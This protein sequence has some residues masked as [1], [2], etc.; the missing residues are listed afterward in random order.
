M[1]SSFSCAQNHCKHQTMEKET[2]REA[3][4]LDM[5]SSITISLY[6]F[7]NCTSPGNKRLPKKIYL[8]HYTYL[9]CGYARES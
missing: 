5:N 9:A 8:Q 2:K 1:K 7:D 4:E 6:P 3:S